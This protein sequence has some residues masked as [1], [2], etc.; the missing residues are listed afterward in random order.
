[1]EISS[2]AN[3]SISFLL[4]FISLSIHEYGHAMTAYKLGDDTPYLCG[5]VSINPFVHID[6]M[7]TIL[8]PLIC[9]FSSAGI[10]FGWGKP[11]PMDTSKFKHPGFYSVLAGSAG[12]FGNLLL[13]LIASLVLVFFPSCGLLAYRLIELNALLIAFNLIPLPGLDGFYFFKYF[14]KLSQSTITFLENWGFFIILI[15]IYIPIVRALLSMLVR[16]ILTFF[17]QGLPHLLGY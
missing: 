5:R 4:L 9:I 13:C 1:M 16:G 12:V 11:V 15:L 2:I 17:I 3:Y 10:L 6:I 7:G 14:F 8:F